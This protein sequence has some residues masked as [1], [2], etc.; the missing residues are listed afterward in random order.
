[1]ATRLRAIVVALAIVF[2]GCDTA[3]L[4]PLEMKAVE[5]GT[6]VGADGAVTAPTRVFAPDDTVHLAIRTIGGGDATLSVRWIVDNKIAHEEQKPV[7]L[8]GPTHTA[9]QFKPANGWPVG[10]S[11]ALFWMNE[12]DKHTVEFEVR[13]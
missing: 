5:V 7:E 2:G 13:G 3:A 8:R 6:A 4:L 11:R 9:F 1:M 12:A 10:T